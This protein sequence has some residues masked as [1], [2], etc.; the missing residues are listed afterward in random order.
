ME[1]STYFLL[2]LQNWQALWLSIKL[3]SVST[4]LLILLGTPLAW[5]L[6]NSKHKSTTVIEAIIALPLVLPPT[7]MGFYLLLAFAPDTWLGFSWLNL[8]GEPLAFSFSG[9]VLGSL[10]YSLPFVVQPLQTAF[11][12]IDQ[13]YLESASTLGISPRARFF[14]IVMPLSR[15]GFLTAAT[16]GFA[17]TLGE[18]GIVLMIGGSIPGETLVSSIAIFQHVETLEYTEAHTLSAIL[19]VGSFSMLL[20][21]YG[22]NKKYRYRTL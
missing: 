16:L 19:I 10:I 12:G 11:S 20:F 1:D 3:A 4:F 14:S 7:V 13:H 15:Y 18:F 21:I 8:T 5:W 2:S 6:H 17:H 9:L 22:L